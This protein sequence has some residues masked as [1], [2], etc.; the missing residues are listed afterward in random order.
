MDTLYLTKI[1]RQNKLDRTK[2][3]TG[4][5]LSNQKEQGRTKIGYN[6]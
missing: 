4:W 1:K 2:N 5:K 6:L 3:K